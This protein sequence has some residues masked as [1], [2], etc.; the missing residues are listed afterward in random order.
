MMDINR[1]DLNLLQTL[2]ALL[3]EKNV[4]RAAT[5]LHR[6]Q[7][8]V[9]A[10]LARLRKLLGDPL[11]LPAQRG[12]TP[13]ARA[14]ELEEPLRE[15]LERLR[16][17]LTSGSRFDPRTAR[18][19][20]AVA[21]SDYVQYAILLPLVVGLRRE[22]PNLRLSLRAIDGA[23]LAHQ[24]EAGEVDLALMTLSTAPAELRSRVLFSERYVCIARKNHPGLKRGLTIDRFCALEHLVV[25]PRGGGFTGPADRALGSIGR[26]GNVVVSA[27]HFLL[28]PE[29]VA[30]SDLIALVPERLV[31][32]LGKR[33]RVLEPPLGV[34]GFT[35]GMV[36]HERTH[37]HPGFGWFR[38]RLIKAVG[39]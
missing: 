39:E 33:L 31:R 1:L 18:L 20:I 28:V 38:D 7:P 34:E 32:G 4:T 30:R 12:M 14:R 37:A 2:E 8:A 15:A 10:Q 21:A 11:L 9:S 36:W 16:S 5:R 22:A 23:R 24:M 6:S 29:I 13:T 25:S 19:N 3:A 17:V 27:S 35:I 26:A